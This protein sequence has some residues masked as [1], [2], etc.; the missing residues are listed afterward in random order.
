MESRA[1]YVIQPA[2]SRPVRMPAYLKN[3]REARFVTTAPTSQCFAA[4]LLSLS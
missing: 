1:A 4:V 2:G 3:A